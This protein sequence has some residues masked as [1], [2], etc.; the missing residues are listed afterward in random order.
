M[1]IIEVRV[2][3]F[4][5]QEVIRLG[6]CGD[7]IDA[8][9]F[10]SLEDAKYSARTRGEVIHLAYDPKLYRA[11]PGRRGG[12]YVN[13]HDRWYS[14]AGNS[15]I[16]YDCWPVGEVDSPPDL[17]DLASA[18]QVAEWCRIT[19]QQPSKEWPAVVSR[20]EG[21]WRSE[22]SPGCNV[23]DMQFDHPGWQPSG[24][25]VETVLTDGTRIRSGAPYQRRAYVTR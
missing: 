11:V 24:S 4:R 19:G 14:V 23:V 10:A 13:I 12:R 8:E 20:A 16:C 7:Y 6:F 18:E 25:E 1:K 21:E 9:Y 15:G 17:L 3:T 2:D 5:V 22:C